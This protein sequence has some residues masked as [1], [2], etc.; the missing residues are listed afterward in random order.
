MERV[1][2]G[3]RTPESGNLLYRHAKLILRQFDDARSAIRQESVAPSGRVAIGFPHQHLAGGGRTAARA[4]ARE[5]PACRA[6]TGRRL[7]LLPRVAG[8]AVAAASG[9][10]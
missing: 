2:Q 6:E 5:I 4:H 10:Y 1:S 3:T 7:Q 8:R 9:R